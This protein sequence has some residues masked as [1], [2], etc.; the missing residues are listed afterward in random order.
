MYIKR[1]IAEIKGKEYKD[2]PIPPYQVFEAKFLD[3]KKGMREYDMDAFLS[4]KNLYQW[5]KKTDWFYN[6]EY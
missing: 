4:A 5:D 2:F 6:P 3:K 1:K